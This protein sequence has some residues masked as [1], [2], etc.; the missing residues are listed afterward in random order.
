MLNSNNLFKLLIIAAA[1]VV[2]T[3]TT[4]RAAQAQEV[5]Y[6]QGT[7][8]RSVDYGGQSNEKARAM[9]IDLLIS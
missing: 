9:I 8:D 7:P 6:A 1:L 2:I 4:T 5:V 3:T